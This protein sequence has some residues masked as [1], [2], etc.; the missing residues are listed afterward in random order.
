MYAAMH[1]AGRLLKGEESHARSR[2]E[3]DVMVNNHTA[4]WGSFWQDG[5]WGYACCHQFN[6]NSYCL[7]EV[8][9]LPGRGAQGLS[10]R[11][12][13]PAG[14]TSCLTSLLRSF[15]LNRRLQRTAQPAS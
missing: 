1:G 15:L 6:K 2:Y 7:G 9:R 12:S 13:G 4:I 14:S 5:Q 10:T 3:E 11:P 8:R